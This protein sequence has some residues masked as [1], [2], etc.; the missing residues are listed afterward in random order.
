METTCIN[1]RKAELNKNGHMNFYNW[2]LQPNSLYIGRNMELY[3]GGTSASKWANPYPVKIYG[4]D[5][6]L[7]M[8]EKYVRDTP[9][10]YNS[11]S[12]LKGKVLGCW[13]CPE[14][15]HGNVLIKLLKEVEQ[16]NSTNNVV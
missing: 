10:L 3:V 11:L 15:C 13:C 2:K 1:V 5:K 6:C 7:E 12:E 16:N 9:E 4:R 8:Y 14:P